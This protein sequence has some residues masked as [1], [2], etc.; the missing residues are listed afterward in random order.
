MMP[1][2]LAASCMPWPTDMAAA[3]AVCAHRKPRL[4]LPGWPFRNS[5][6]IASIIRKPRIRP[7][8]GESTIGMR[9]FSMMV[10][11]WTMPS[12][13]NRVAP[14]RPPKR[15]CE[16]EDGRPKYQVIRFQMIAPSTPAKTTP[17]LST[18]VGNV[19]SPSPTVLATPAPKCAPTK[20]PTAA[21]AS[22]IRGVSARV[23][24]L[25]AIALAASWKPFV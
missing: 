23:E 25:V 2:V 3:D 22:A 21:S 13:A 19:T 7:T 8:T 12:A 24:I 5:H 15:A 9:T 18:P 6:M 14:T 10:P 20:L 16:D 4:S 11:H 1:M 17:R